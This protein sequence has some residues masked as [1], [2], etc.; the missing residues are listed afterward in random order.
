MNIHLKEAFSRMKPVCDMVMINPS[1]DYITEFESL[2]SELKIDVLQE[3]HQ[4]M[5]FPFIT[6][7]QSKEIENKYEMQR[8]LVHG[9]KV[10][11]QR[12]KITSYEMCLKIEVAFMNL[13]FDKTK[14]GMVANVPEELKLSV[15]ECLT[16]LMINLEP[17]VRLKLLQTQVPLLAQTV[18]L[19]V[20]L[21]KLE[22]LRTLR[23]AAIDS[24]NA[25]I[26][27]HRTLTDK[28]GR[29]TDPAIEKAVVHMTSSILPGVLASLQDVATCTDN[30][31]HAVIVAALDAICRIL[32]LT[33]ND[34]FF[35]TNKDITPEDFMNLLKDKEE[36]DDE[37]TR[38][39]KL[40]TATKLS[41]EWYTMA[42]EKLKTVIKSVVLLVTHE[43]HRV[44]KELAVLCHRVLVDCSETM[45]SSL[46]LCVEVL[47]C[48]TNDPY[49]EVSE[50][51]SK[52]VQDHFSRNPGVEAMESLRDNFILA[53]NN[54]PRVLNNIDTS[55]KLNALDSVLGYARVLAASEVRAGCGGRSVDVRLGGVAGGRAL[56][57]DRL[58]PA[59]LALVAAA[60]LDVPPQ[61]LARR[62]ACEAAEA[63]ACAGG[64]RGTPWRS[65][66]NVDPGLPEERLR[67][68][69]GALGSLS[70]AALLFD[71]LLDELRAG[72]TEP[73]LLINW[74]AT[75]PDTDESLARRL[76][77][78][79]TA[80][81]VWACPLEDPTPAPPPD[82]YDVTVYDPHAWT[83]DSVPGLYEG[84]TETRYTGISYLHPRRPQSRASA[85][86]ARRGV[87]RRCLMAE[88]LELAA[89]RLGPA[90]RPHLLRTLTL[91]LEAVGSKFEFVS[92][93]GAHALANIAVALGHASVGAL[94]AENADYCTNQIATRL[95]KA[96]SI[97]SALEMLSVVI[98]YSDVA[99]LEYLHGIV[100]DVLVQSCD[101]YYQQDLYSFLLV[102]HTFVARLRQW[103][104]EETKP[105][106]P[107]Q[108]HILN[109]LNEYIQNQREAEKLMAAEEMED[110]GK[111][112]EEM[113]REDEL[114]REEEMLD[115]D[116]NVEPEAAPLPQHA[117]AVVYVAERCV[118]FA[119]SGDSG[120]AALALRVLS[121]AFPLLA[122]H[123]DALLPLAHAAW[124]PLAAAA[125]ADPPVL[126]AALQ[127]LRVLARLCGDFIRS[128][129]VKDIL[130]SL[131]SFLRKSSSDS[132]LQD[133][134]AA[135][136]LSRAY[137]LQLAVLEDVPALVMHLQL[138]EDTMEETMSCVRLYL[139][140]KQ[141]RPLQELAVRCFKKFLEYNYGAAWQHLRRLCNNQSS[142][143]PPTVSDESDIQLVTVYGTPY[144]TA[145]TDF[146]SNIRL[147]FDIK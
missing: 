58:R 90:Y 145:D 52:A 13:I 62:T 37:A 146:D 75:G 77:C 73:I 136:R 87:L 112:A 91:V 99:I 60:A 23:L 2:V 49:M 104:P 115:Y 55:R 67:A 89:R 34:K 54:L 108:I 123:E 39:R 78:E 24:V 19:S 9:M 28:M 71:V 10:V 118:Q 44:R 41:R 144:E 25:H 21:A 111:S 36:G 38:D 83:K 47:I 134:G 59:A 63:V 11:I 93:A 22:K 26:A 7:L 42:G 1:P 43:H 124:V 6:H 132:Y 107:E 133:A 79:Y 109:D 114:R 130:P 74:I 72:A 102:F 16:A 8:V 3:L 113:Y 27:C 17:S 56:P 100:D 103:F 120:C 126:R 139:S 32:C 12:V 94:I 64:E 137:A 105:E 138:D 106:D 131:H 128:R 142:L 18:F 80:E 45:L 68:V 5:L 122:S 57:Y 110:A 84:A 30:P 33:M 125:R 48:L 129:T 147:I 140:R 127:L 14:K 101:R 135:Y 51:C 20:H 97:S 95:K 46:P 98:Q 35:R 4:Y 69:C 81:E 61:L 70:A 121:E 29:I 66:L 53:I 116:D 76:V 82:T 50:Y 40:K 143:E 141:P 31:G 119:A 92:M 65:L 86:A 88:G 15:M 117:R 96:W 85:A